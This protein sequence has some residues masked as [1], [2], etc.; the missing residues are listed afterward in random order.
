MYFVYLII[1]LVVCFNSAKKK[2]KMFIQTIF[3]QFSYNL[4]NQIVRYIHIDSTN[5]APF[6]IL[7]F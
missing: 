6:R 2:Q 5:F 3:L 1:T 4:E 7:C